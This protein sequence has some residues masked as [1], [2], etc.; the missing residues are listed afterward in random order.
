MSLSQNLHTI[1]PVGLDDTFLQLYQRVND[2]ISV[3]NQIRIYDVQGTGGI[4]HRR[5][6]V[7]N[8]VAREVLS[9]NL[10]ST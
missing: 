3:V 8:P 6:V 7:S 1:S 9:I 4:I 5:D 2:T 10:A